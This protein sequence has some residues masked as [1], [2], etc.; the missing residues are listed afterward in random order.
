M[1]GSVSEIDIH[2]FVDMIYFI[3]TG[4]EE[5]AALSLLK[6]SKIDNDNLDETLFSREVGDVI[7]THFYGSLK[8]INIVVIMN[9]MVRLM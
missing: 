6:L 8:E 3:F 1:M 9:D 7:R 2:N 5:K 4:E